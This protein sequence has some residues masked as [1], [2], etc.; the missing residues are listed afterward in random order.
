MNA[1]LRAAGSGVL[2]SFEAP[3]TIACICNQI[4]RNN[5]KATPAI[6]QPFLSRENSSNGRQSPPK[7]S[8][9]ILW[10]EKGGCQGNFR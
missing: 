3:A 6:G 4:L 2:V 1:T 7:L 9:E 5:E 8:G 10:A